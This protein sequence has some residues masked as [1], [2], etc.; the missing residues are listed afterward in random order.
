MSGGVRAAKAP[1][2]GPRITEGVRATAA[3]IIAAGL[4]SRLKAARPDMPKPLVEVRG[5][6]LVHWVTEGLRRAGFKSIVILLNS[7]GDPVRRYL[8]TNFAAL[9]WTF[10]RQ[11]TRSSWETF[12]IV[13]SETARRAEALD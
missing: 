5:K 9:D 13:S 2:A 8:E 7:S 10:L 1:C 6:P 3:G 4:G 12:Q 11:D